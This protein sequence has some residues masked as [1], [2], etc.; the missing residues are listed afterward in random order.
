M[1]A[2]LN[3]TFFCS[4]I[5]F[6]FFASQGFSL[7]EEM[8]DSVAQG[9]R[10]DLRNPEYSQGVLSTVEGGVIETSLLRIQATT[11]QYTHTSETAS[12]VAFG[13]LMINYGP[14]VLVGEKIEYDF[15]TGRGVL[16]NGRSGLD[17]W[18]F[19]GKVI[20]LIPEGEIIIQE[21]FVTTSENVNREW[22]IDADIIRIDS[23]HNVLAKNLHFR[24]NRIPVFWLPRLKTNLDS[25]FDSPIRYRVRWGGEEGVRLGVAYEIL[26]WCGW[27]SL[28]RFDY[29]IN[30][31]PGG[32][33]ETYYT[34]PSGNHYLKSIN[35][36][37]NDPPPEEPNMLTRYRLEGI[38]HSGFD[39]DRLTIDLRYDKLSD[40]FMARD[41]NDHGLDLNTAGLT[42][43][44]IRR[45]SDQM[46]ITNFTTRVRLNSF[47]TTKEELPSLMITSHP[48]N[49][50]NTGVIFE[51]L[52][53]AGYLDFLYA[54]D[55]PVDPIT[56]EEPKDFHSSRLEWQSR[57]YRPTC[58]G[59]TIFTPE[60]SLTAI[61]YENTEK[62]DARYVICG[63]FGAE[64]NAPLYRNYSFG[65]HAIEPYLKYEWITKPTTSPTQHFVFDITDG[66]S[67]LNI[68]RFGTRNTI[69]TD[70]W[71]G[72]PLR[73]LYIDSYAYAFFDS[74]TIPVPI[75][76]IYT[77]F[78][79]NI[80]PTLRQTATFAY[81]I[82]KKLVDHYNAR[83]EWTINENLA[84][85]TEF[86]HRSAF[87]WRKAVYD[88][89]ILENFQ[90]DTELRKTPLSDQRNTF[91]GN[92]FLRLSPALAFQYQ[93]RHGWD[94]TDQ[95]AYTES[96]FDVIMKLRG[97][98]NLRISYRNRENEKHRFAF[99]I[100]L[101]AD[102]P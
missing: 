8:R 66:W 35:Y 50:W 72:V 90:T 10:V 88:N 73:Y 3:L 101:G 44:N 60:A 99:Y 22:E 79:W 86:R 21:G 65:R 63:I 59:P 18:Y 40:Q 5:S 9:I 17:P 47:Q 93:I 70:D 7:L 87:S 64:V 39:C 6:L 33:I 1:H 11:I 4:L 71:C 95:P 97:S 30:R 45:Q 61:W 58:L 46:F 76:K 48:I 32:G 78:V 77:D 67:D 56:H 68:L 74:H 36:I 42:Q 92:I 41:Y 91:L 96:V 26:K 82:Q 85:S 49:L 25:I 80:Y 57:L 98:W 94:R 34:S 20:R 75:P 43:L 51:M 52:G 62:H 102:K 81:D 89:F 38:Y 27:T 100:S 16:I 28:L 54:D 14:Y 69:F 23:E 2:K 13:Q 37:A 83:I 53:R 19:G 12:V 55:T 15:I 24:I 29:R 84:L 31:G